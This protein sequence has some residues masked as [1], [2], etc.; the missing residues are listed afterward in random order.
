MTGHNGEYSGQPWFGQAFTYE[1]AVME[2]STGLIGHT[3][4]AR[5]LW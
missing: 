3:G 5:L 1:A 4:Q 2:G